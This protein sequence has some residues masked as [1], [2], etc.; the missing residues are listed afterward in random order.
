MNISLGLTC[1]HRGCTS[2][3]KARGLCHTHYQ[4]EWRSGRHQELPCLRSVQATGTVRRLQ[5]LIFVGHLET[6][7]AEQLGMTQ[8]NLTTLVHGHHDRVSPARR[9]EVESLFRDLWDVA[10][11]GWV[12]DRNRRLA[13]RNGWLG[14]LAWDDIDTDPE[15]AVVDSPEQPIGLRILEDVEWL[16]E[17]GE[18]VEQIETALG[19][20][21]AT[22][23]KLAYRHGR[24]DLAN[25]FGA[26]AKRIRH[27][28]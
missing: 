27:A 26:Y 6:T 14:P 19:K 10:P 28:A 22:I 17:G 24:D 8:A 1:N 20:N 15:P 5:A 7:L 18:T 9:D 2:E 23:S 11:E 21:A 16:L 3:A 25:R 13:A 4:R 12:H